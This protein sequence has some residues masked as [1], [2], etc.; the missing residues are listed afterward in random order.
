MMMGMIHVE[1]SVDRIQ[2][3]PYPCTPTI[4]ID[5]NCVFDKLWD[6]SKIQNEKGEFETVTKNVERSMI[7]F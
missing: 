4:Q 2:T 1:A 6:Y 5:E 7:L 3:Y